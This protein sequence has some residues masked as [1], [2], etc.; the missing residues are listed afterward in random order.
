MAAKPKKDVIAWPW[1]P[2][3]LEP[4]EISAIKAMAAQ[5]AIAFNTVCEKICR[6]HQ[7]SFTAGG[8]DGRRATDYA[9]GK[10]AVAQTL[11]GIVKRKMPSPVRSDPSRGPPPGENEAA[12]GS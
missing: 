11:R 7:I 6:E 1:D 10:R 8:E 3:M 4:H 5:H 12:P 2:V 9:E